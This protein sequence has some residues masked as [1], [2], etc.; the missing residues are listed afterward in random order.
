M[1][2]F[3]YWEY[4]RRQYF[5]KVHTFGIFRLRGGKILSLVSSFAI[6]VCALFLAIELAKLPFRSALT[7]FRYG[8]EA[9]EYLNGSY[10]YFAETVRKE[11]ATVGAVFPS[12]DAVMAILVQV[13]SLMSYLLVGLRALFI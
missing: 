11:A 13:G 9:R 5:L 2:F 1:R 8:H 10:W 7:L 3:L 12:P 4:I 6:H